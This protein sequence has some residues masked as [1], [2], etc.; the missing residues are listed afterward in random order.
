M[1]PDLLNGNL[2]VTL[3]FFF[4]PNINHKKRY[5]FQM[6]NDLQTIATTIYFDYDWIAGSY[7]HIGSHRWCWQKKSWAKHT[8][9]P[10]TPW[11]EWLTHG[12][13]GPSVVGRCVNGTNLIQSL[14]W[15]PI[16]IT[17]DQPYAY[18]GGHLVWSF[19][20]HV[21]PHWPWRVWMG[22]WCNQL[23]GYVSIWGFP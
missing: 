17:R 16:T 21:L 19:H 12:L 22:S 2:R 20:G 23:D 14:R 7:C 6:C 1:Y 8:W 15:L 4:S 18:H 13:L 10:K 5:K 9:I 3:C 11:H